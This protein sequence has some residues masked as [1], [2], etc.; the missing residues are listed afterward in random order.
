MRESCRAPSWRAVAAERSI[1]LV[2]LLERLP[3]PKLIVG[4]TRRSVSAIEID[5][6]R[7]EPGSLFVAIPGEHTDGIL[8]AAQ[9][10]ANG[11][12]VVIAQAEPPS[13]LPADVTFV[14]VGDARRALSALAAAYYGEPSRSLDVIGI[15][16]TNGKTTTAYMI[17]SILN[18]A[19]VACGIAGTVGGQFGSRRWHLANT[20][21]LPPELHRVIAEMRD[22]GAKAIAL[23]VSSHALALHRVDDVR[24]RV[25]ALTNVTRDH[26]D[27]HQT[28]EAYAAAKHRLF[29]MTEACVLNVDDECGARWAPRLQREGRRVV[30]YGLRAAASLTPKDIVVEPAVNRFT[31]DRRR[32]TVQLSGRFNIWNALAAIGVAQVLDID[33]ATIARGLAEL[34]CV[35]GRMERIEADGIAVVV[36][37]AHTPD[38]L[39]N[40]LRSLRETARGAVTVVF[41]CGGDRDEGKR[42]EMGAIAGRLADRVY[43]TNDNPRGEEP[44][45]IADA[46]VAGIGNSDAV[47]ELDRRRA[48]ERAIG[49]ATTGDVVLVA[50]KGHETYQIVGDRVLA[51]DDAQVARQTLAARA[52]LR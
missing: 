10:V 26:L 6:R 15:T 19:G 24:F 11:A 21:P 43:V 47:V 5:S 30:T 14:R 51:F 31:V 35:P 27:F 49:D 28:G 44:Q 22:G 32:Y 9:A 18:A 29:G 7:V 36:D 13:S 41:G 33:D 3:E 39:E 2:T 20:T 52:A 25:A 1:G 34:D 37:Y 23:E 50:G 42:P 12:G 38:A 16:G 40:A 8:Y 48:I 45:A 17:A 46:I 4:D